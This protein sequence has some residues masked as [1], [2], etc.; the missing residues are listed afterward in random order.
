MLDQA[1]LEKYY[2]EPRWGESSVFD[3]E[4][5][6]THDATMTPFRSRSQDMRVISGQTALFHT[7]SG[8]HMSPE[9]EHPLTCTSACCQEHRT[10]GIVRNVLKSQSIAACHGG[11]SRTIV[12]LHGQCLCLQTCMQARW[13]KDIDA[14]QGMPLGILSR[15]PRFSVSTV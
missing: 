14:L 13:L 12:T 7:V 15:S 4:M 3:L 10:F 9:R 6:C 5:Q 1:Y 2:K 11:L 8:Y